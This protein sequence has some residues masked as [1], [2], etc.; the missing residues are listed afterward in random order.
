MTEELQTNVRDDIT[1]FRV[2]DMVKV[3]YRITEGDKTRIQPYEGIVISKKGP[4]VSKTFM[5]RRIGADGIG[6]E[7]IFPLSS[8]NIEKVEVIKHGKVRRAKLYYLRDKVGREAMRIK[9]RKPK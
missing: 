8:P 3:F 6:V 1:S 2:G 4:G 7:R 5:V 9:E